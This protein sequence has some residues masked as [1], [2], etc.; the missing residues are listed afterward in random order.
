[1]SE[2][3]EEEETGE[4][5][6][7][8]E[9]AR[10]LAYR[11]SEFPIT[12]R[13]AY[14]GHAAIGPLTRRGAEAMGR[15][16]DQT[17]R[18]ADRHWPDRQATAEAA[19]GHAARLFGARQTHE[20]AFVEN[21]SSA[22]SL[23]A[24]GLAWRRGENVVGAELEFPSNVYPWMQLADLGVEYR[25]VPERDGRI[26]PDEVLAAI[27]E[28]TRIVALSWV[29]YASCFRSDLARLGRFCRERGIL[30]VVDVI[31][32]FGALRLDV[33]R[34]HVDVAAASAH[35]WLF[36]PE[37]I[38]L[39]YVSDR[40]LDCFRPARA[41]WRSVREPFAWSDYDLTWGEGA[42][43]FES[44]TVNVYGLAALEGSLSVLLEAGPEAIERRVL[45]LAGRVADGLAA[46]GFEVV[47]S[48]RPGETSGIVTATHPDPEK[49]GEAFC[50][51][52]AEQGL[53]TTS[54]AGRFRVAPHFYN[55][56]DEV[57][58]L[59]GAV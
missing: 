7:R 35:K 48:R 58:R 46:R 52:L 2:R 16:A 47:S 20:V 51:R 39:L 53:I 9:D 10:L 31:Q 18:T 45:A 11:G 28:G 22:L 25:R 4:E 30:F 21:T 42:K 34:D 27:D 33:E 3:R 41:G 44:G 54:R 29:Q 26:D 59:L 15:M 38:G 55:T 36:G 49:N 32:G 12:E 50:A 24:M 6:R 19:R 56:E 23:V 17:C 40:V 43:R 57:E 37:G 8:A 14:F 13:Y 1:M 5:G